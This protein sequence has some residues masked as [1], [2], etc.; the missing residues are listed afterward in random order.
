MKMIASFLGIAVGLGVFSCKGRGLESAALADSASASGDSNPCSN[1]DASTKA[2]WAQKTI[3]MRLN[4]VPTKPPG[5]LSVEVGAIGSK[6]DC[7]GLTWVYDALGKNNSGSG[8]IP[9]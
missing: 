6:T 1:P 5:L 4:T 3:N 7:R 9:T 8:Q 2:S